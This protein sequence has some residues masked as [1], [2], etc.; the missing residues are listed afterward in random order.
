RNAERVGRPQDTRSDRTPVCAQRERDLADRVL[1]PLPRRVTRDEIDADARLDILRAIVGPQGEDRGGG[2]LPK[3][4]PL[5]LCASIP[6]PAE[7]FGELRVEA[8]R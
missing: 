2:P 7:V 3:I 1:A 4:D 6:D 5:C 8:P